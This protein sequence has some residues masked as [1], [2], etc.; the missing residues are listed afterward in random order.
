ML[1]KLHFALLLRKV[2]RGIII[3]D[4]T[5]TN[6]ICLQTCKIYIIG[7]N[8][9]SSLTYNMSF[10]PINKGDDSTRSM[11]EFVEQVFV[12]YHMSNTPLL[13]DHNRE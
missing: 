11:C 1:Y 10:L 4:L 8:I 13:R 6:Q 5:N 3:T 7:Q 12:I 9:N 2:H